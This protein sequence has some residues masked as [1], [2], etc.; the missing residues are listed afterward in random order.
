LRRIQPLAAKKDFY[1]QITQIYAEK[2][3]ICENLRNLR[4]NTFLPQSGFAGLKKSKKA[5]LF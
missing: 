2:E 3:K 4:I 1:P 5:V